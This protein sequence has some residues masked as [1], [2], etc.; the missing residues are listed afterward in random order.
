MR[1]SKRVTK[2]TQKEIT[3]KLSRVV[4]GSAQHARTLILIREV[5]SDRDKRERGREYEREGVH[6]YGCERMRECKRERERER[7]KNKKRREGDVRIF[8]GT[9]VKGAE[10]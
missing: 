10:S 5:S 9:R 1:E 3:Q 2:R 4:L 7:R 6:V 8:Y